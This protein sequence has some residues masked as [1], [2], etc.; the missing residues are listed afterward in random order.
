MNA[1]Q[2]IAD[3]I[4]PQGLS[5]FKRGDWHFSLAT[6]QHLKYRPFLI[7]LLMTAAAYLAVGIFYKALSLSLMK[8]QTGAVVLEPA[9]KKDAAIRE[10]LESYK[11]VVDR[12]LFASTDKIFGDKQVAEKAS[13][14]D[15]STLFD[16]K[17]T[18]A[19]DGPYGFAILEDKSAKKQRL[20]KVGDSLGGGKVARI[21]RNAIVVRV[22]DEEKT[23]KIA[24]T[25][26]E[27]ILTPHR[28]FVQ[29]LPRSAAGSIAVNRSEVEDGMKNVG[30]LLSQAQI[31]PYFTQGAPDGFLITNIRPGS[32]YQKLGLANGDIIQ[33]IDGRPIKTADDMMAFYNT[34]KDASSVS[35]DI[36][37]QGRSDKLN[38]VF[39]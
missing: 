17:G 33:G 6:L 7:V 4:M 29:T 14:P 19:G 3:K 11:V 39:R 31:R 22:G 18:V 37:R 36:K 25:K 32:L 26:E 35:L 1:V 5:G 15:I 21:L 23:L 30:Q 12:N 20:Y 8:T 34:L 10:P 16:L 9:A 24:E 38:Y 2:R 28:G 27:P 13:Q